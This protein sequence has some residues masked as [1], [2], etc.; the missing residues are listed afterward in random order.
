MMYLP[1]WGLTLI[2]FGALA[3]GVGAAIGWIGWSIMGL[4]GPWQSEVE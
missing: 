3:I 2:I 1:W 4:R